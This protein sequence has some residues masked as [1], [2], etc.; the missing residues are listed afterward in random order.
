MSTI[1]YRTKVSLTK[2]YFLLLERYN[3]ET[4]ITLHFILYGD[5]KKEVDKYHDIHDFI[6][7]ILARKR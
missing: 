2:I 1:N 3:R 6:F 4:T 7:M 5:V